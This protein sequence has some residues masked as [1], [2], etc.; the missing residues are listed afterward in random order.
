M[1]PAP[2]FYVMM[3]VDHFATSQ[4][5]AGRFQEEHRS[6]AAGAFAQATR[7][8]RAGRLVTLQG[9][10]LGD[11]PESRERFVRGELMAALRGCPD[12]V[13]ELWL[14]FVSQR[15]DMLADAEK[16]ARAMALAS[17][18]RNTFAVFELKHEH[19]VLH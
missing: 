6:A 13:A 8:H 4:E 15:L 11:A 16:I 17:R 2:G 19:E 14:V 12:R 18:G 3:F 5:F 1:T 7:E 9:V 10:P